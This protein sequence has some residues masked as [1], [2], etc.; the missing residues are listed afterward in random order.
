MP[1]SA[2]AAFDKAAQYFGLKLVKI[3]VGPDWRADVAA[4]ERAITPNTMALVGSAPSFPHGVIDPIP[5]LAALAQRHNIACHVD[6]CL[7]GFVLPWAERLGYDVP[8][9]D[10]RLPG[11]TSMSAD[12]HKYGYAAKGT[13]VVL[14]A[15]PSCAAINTYTVADWPGGLYFSPTFAGSRPG[16]LSAAGWAALVSIGEAGYLDATKDPGDGGQDQERHPGDTG[17][18][19]MGDPLW[20]IAFR[21]PS[22]HLPGHRRHEGA[23]LEPERPAQARCRAHL[24]DPAPHAA[25]RGRAVSGGPE[26]CRGAREG[27]RGLPGG[28]APVYGMADTLPGPRHHCRPAPEAHG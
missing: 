14:Y 19:V 18:H 22:G 27:Q 23:R 16:A 20:V 12:T 17:R 26:G 13:S 9:F 28:L 21:H 5:D 15:G 10:F 8:P 2:H 3:P 25:G 24:R 11:V 7:G 4:T 1:T 6:A